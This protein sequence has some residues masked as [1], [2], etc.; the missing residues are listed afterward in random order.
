MKNKLSHDENLLRSTVSNDNPGIK[1]N[2]AIEER[3]NYYYTIKQPNREI[4]MNSFGGMFIWLFSMKSLGLKASFISAGLAYLLFFGNIKND[5]SNPGYS[6][7]CQIH[8]LVAD[9]NFIVKDT[10]K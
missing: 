3:L 1:P 10:C 7:S 9:T 2:K 4:H 8:T 5:P 6:D